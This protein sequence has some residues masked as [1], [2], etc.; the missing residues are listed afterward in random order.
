MRMTTTT[1]I[2]LTLGCAGGK[3]STSDSGADPAS[4]SDGG[5]LLLD[6]TAYVDGA[7]QVS[8]VGVRADGQEG[9]LVTDFEQVLRVDLAT[10]EVVG[11]FSVQRGDLPEQGASEAVDYRPDGSLAV[12]FPEDSV[13]GFYSVDGAP[14]GELA[15]PEGVYHGGMV[16]FDNDEALVVADGPLLRRID[17]D[18]GALVS[19][20]PLSGVS[21]EVEGLGFDGAA[22]WAVVKDNG[23]YRVSLEGG[24]AEARYTA[25]EVGEASGVAV[26]ADEEEV[27]VIISDDD[28]AYNAEPGPLRL[29]LL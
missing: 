21:E 15:L 20:V 11:S 2:A 29:Y 13:I 12:L 14:L 7:V 25:D 9:V 24:A 17:L 6:Y 3:S 1:L 27:V 18:D 5:T 4:D 28:D 10:A 22:L 23:V 8:G 16:V 19:E 26:L